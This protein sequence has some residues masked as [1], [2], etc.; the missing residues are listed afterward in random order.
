MIHLTWDLYQK[1]SLELKELYTQTLLSSFQD[2]I[3]IMYLIFIL[4]I[5]HQNVYLQNEQ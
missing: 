2:K 5:K 1:P 4:L 3:N